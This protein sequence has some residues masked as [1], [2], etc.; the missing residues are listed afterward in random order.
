MSAAPHGSYPPVSKRVST[1][2]GGTMSDEP[3]RTD[4]IGEIGEQAFALWATQ[5]RFSATKVTYDKFGW[6]YLISARPP[7]STRRLKLDSPVLTC[8]VQVKTTQRSD[9][10]IKIT[11]ANMERMATSQMP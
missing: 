6:D 11:L 5:A 9:A 1:R 3:L 8:A 7:G 10:H 4:E 2:W